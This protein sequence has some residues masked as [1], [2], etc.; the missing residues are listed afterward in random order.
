MLYLTIIGAAFVTW[1]VLVTLFTPV[2]PYHVEAPVD[3]RSASFSHVIESACQ[4]TLEAGNRIDIFTN[5]PSFYPAML[6]AIRAARETVNLECYIFKSG[7]VATRLIDALTT[8]S[9][10]LADK[11]QTIVSMIDRLNAVLGNLAAHQQDL[12]TLL[13]ATDAASHDTAN[14]VS[15]NRATLDGTLTSLHGVLNVLADHQV[16]LAATVDYL[17]QA[18]QGYSSVGY[19]CSGTRTPRHALPPRLPSATLASVPRRRS[20][21]WRRLCGTPTRRRG[22]RSR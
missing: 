3:P 10:T 5:G 8:L 20:P 17:E 22:G 11:D 21:R 13:V 14:L 6:A 1:L 4:A 16:D 15:R 9:G 2:I 19:S 12:Q 18:V 7:E